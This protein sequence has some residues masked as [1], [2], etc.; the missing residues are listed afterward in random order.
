MDRP[1]FYG[2]ET[3]TAIPRVTS[4]YSSA[5]S[6]PRWIWVPQLIKGRMVSLVGQGDPAGG[7]G[8]KAGAVFAAPMIARRR[9]EKPRRF[10]GSRPRS[11]AR[12]R[13]KMSTAG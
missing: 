8:E 10:P 7:R 4:A 2:R 12:T 3:L 5:H 13:G 1:A 9:F 11:R 6:F